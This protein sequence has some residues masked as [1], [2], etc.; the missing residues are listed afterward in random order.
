MYQ[1]LCQV[2]K[3]M[4]FLWSQSIQSHPASDQGDWSQKLASLDCKFLP[5]MIPQRT[6]TSPLTLPPVSDCLSFSL[7]ITTDTMIRLQKSINYISKIH[8][9]STRSN[10]RIS[11]VGTTP[12]SPGCQVLTEMDCCNCF[13]L[14]VSP[15]RHCRPSASWEKPLELCL[16]CWKPQMQLNQLQMLLN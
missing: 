11:G 2:N 13:S 16:W 15:W 7:L 1:T 4:Q 8:N 9:L 6:I 14:S 5:A 12:Q 10:K 3:T